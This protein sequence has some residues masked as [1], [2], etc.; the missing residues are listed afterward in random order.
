MPRRS[1]RRTIRSF[2]VLAAAVVVC[3]GLVIAPRHASAGT[4]TPVMGPPMLTAQELAGWYGRHHGS[5]VPQIPAFN[6]NVAQLAQVFIDQGKAEGVRGD[7]AFAQ[8]MLETGWLSFRNSQIP[9]DAYNY[10]GI[11]AYDGR[12]GLPNCAHG[13]AY[14][15]R[16]MGSPQHGVLVQIQLLRSYADASTRSMTGRLISAP[17]DRIG[18]APLWEWF[19]GHDCP[20]G[21]LIWASADGYGLYILNMYQQALAEAGKTAWCV[22]YTPG[23]YNGSG[24]GYYEVSADKVVHPIGSAGFFGDTRSTVLGAPIVG[25]DSIGSTGYWIVTSNGAVYHY[26]SAADY[27]SLTTAPT[28]PIVGMQ[29]TRDTLG[30]WLV[31]ADGKVYPFGSA[32]NLDF[33]GLTDAP[34]S[35]IIGMSRTLSG[36][37]Y[38]LFGQNGAV[39]A[40]GDAVLYGSQAPNPPHSPFMAA[41]RTPDNKGYWLVTRDGR[42]FPFGSAG[43]FGDLRGCTYG[44][45]VGLISSPTG[46]GYWIATAI[47]AVVPFGDARQLGAPPSV[48]G[49]VVGFFSA[50]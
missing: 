19:G 14:P 24:S 29:R 17:S 38:Y 4:Q 18:A 39:Y 30:Y 32:K 35:P 46:Q 2:A 6:N 9:P 27:G 40:K 36:N 16:C 34:A 21:K 31:G 43:R 3:A 15:S 5:N 12:V 13:D 45:A 1:A 25:G 26:G 22:P 49:V 33:G 28:A 10:A 42:L 37:G 7:I 50:S 23:H 11:Y 44:G 48:G 41:T 47:G 8:S 20:C